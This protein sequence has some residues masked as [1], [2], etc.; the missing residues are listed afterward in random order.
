MLALARVGPLRS[1]DA[2]LPWI[3]TNTASSLFAPSCESAK[4]LRSR[5]I[6]SSLDTHRLAGCR[7]MGVLLYSECCS[8]AGGLPQPELTR[9]TKY[10]CGRVRAH[11]MK[12]RTNTKSTS[13]DR[14]MTGYYYK[15][16]LRSRG[17]SP[18]AHPTSF[19]QVAARICHQLRS[20]ALS[21]LYP[22]PH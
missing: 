17:A 15:P 10:C 11:N 14:T 7:T 9:H 2:P 3:T 22:C 21:R 13:I 19:V 12:S 1:A 18:L 8:G 6:G 16:L 4:R 5:V 20:L